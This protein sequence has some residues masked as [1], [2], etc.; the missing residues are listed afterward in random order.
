[1]NK[2]VL[3]LFSLAVF[4]LSGCS[5]VKTL[6]YET[7]QFETDYEQ[8]KGSLKTCVGDGKLQASGSI[9]GQ[10]LFSF[11][12]RND[13][14]YI[15]FKDIL[16]R[17]TMYMQLHQ[18]DMTIW[19]MRKNRIYPYELFIE[20]FPTLRFLSA[21]DLTQFLWGINPFDEPE[22]LTELNLSNISLVF[23]SEIT[24]FGSVTSGLDFQDKDNNHTIALDITNREYG[25]WRPSIVRSIPSTAKWN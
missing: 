11:T 12:S 19:D 18:E 10:L 5:Q 16:S 6:S 9:T 21:L 22:D 4:L 20:Q 7:E 23:K 14:T 1:M 8:L 15:L 25:N 24:Q 2:T 17:R 3:V 13:S